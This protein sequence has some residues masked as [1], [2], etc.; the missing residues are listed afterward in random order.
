MKPEAHEV[1][2]VG[3]G[4]AGI[5][6]VYR[7][8]EAGLE[9]LGLEAAPDVGGV[10]YH[11]CYPGARCDLLSVDYS[12][13]FSEELQRDWRW[14]HRYADQPEILAYM[15]HV[16]DRF[17][18]RQQFRFE[19]RVTGLRRDDNT[20]LWLVETD[21]GKSYTARYVILATGPLSV[22]KDPDFPGYD[23]FKGEKY[24][25]SRWPHREVSFAGKR[26]GVIGTGSSGLQAI[27]AIAG[28][29]GHLTVFQRTPAFTA[30]AHNRPVSDEEHDQFLTAYPAYRSKM[31]S[32]HVGGYMFS[33]GKLVSECSPQEQREIMD[34]YYQEG[35]IGYVSAFTDVLVNEEANAVV[36]D[37][38]REKI[39]T[40]VKDPVLREK[41]TPRGFPVGARR[42]CIDTAY[43][44]AFNR[45]NVEL[46]D[47]RETPIVRFTEQGIE[48]TAGF[49]PLDMAIV[50]LGFDAG[51][52]AALSIDPVNGAGR[53]LSA[54]WEDGPQTCLGMTVADFPNLFLMNSPGGT[55]VFGNVPIVSEWEADWIAVCITWVHS[56]GK[57]SI[58]ASAAAQQMWTDE[59]RAI[60][61]ATL[62]M[63]APS[64]YS[65]GNIPGKKR[66]ILAYVGGFDTYRERG[67]QVA[68]NGYAGFITR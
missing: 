29:V 62:L 39:A 65:G 46:V 60:G 1:I 31:K 26:V 66:G 14:S 3:A 5:Y 20:N 21:A 51:T 4:F 27:G 67:K 53:A 64:W 41:L 37:Y 42:P 57:S 22:P 59:L 18:L 25:A 13:S 49:H 58:E 35:G 23:E 50:A 52:G 40:R 2:V 8:R 16:V 47:L 12:Y 6:A 48:T 32:N 33:T 36:A 44:E 61:E 7:L 63:Q 45:E 54:A 10:W 43:L 17:D 19:T 38:L 30:P 56:Q 9:V 68:D 24:Q 28:Q 55:S 34:S 15:R 11:N